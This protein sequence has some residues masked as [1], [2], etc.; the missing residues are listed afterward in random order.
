MYP[1]KPGITAKRIIDVVGQRLR[2]IDPIRWSSVPITFQ[3][4]FET[5]NGEIDLRTVINIH[6]ALE[7]EF[8][9]DIFDKHTLC[10]DIE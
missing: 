10:T 4:K 3:T 8:H 5:D 2:D 9:I 1:K 6:D 7:K